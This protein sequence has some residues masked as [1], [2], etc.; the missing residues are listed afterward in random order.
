MGSSR[1]AKAAK[2]RLGAG[3]QSDPISE[4][5]NDFLNTV[6]NINE[7]AQ[8][9]F[10]RDPSRA[11]GNA[12]VEQTLRNYF[13]S[14]CYDSSTQNGVDPFLQTAAQVSNFK[15]ERGY[16]FE[17]CIDSMRESASAVN[18]IN[19]MVGMALPMYKNILMNMVWDKGGI[20]HSTAEAQTF[21]RTMKIRQLIDQQGRAIDMFLNQ[22]DMTAAMLSVNPNIDV[23][24]LN[25]ERYNTEIVYAKL[26]GTSFDHIDNTA[27]ISAIKIKDVY[28]PEDS[29]LPD[30]NGIIPESGG[31]VATS[32]TAG[33]Y[34]VWYNVRLNFGPGYGPIKRQLQKPITFKVLRKIGTADP[35]TVT[36]SDVIQAN[37][38]DDL[39]MVT[40]GADVVAVKLNCRIDAS[41]RTIKPCT[42][43]W[44]EITD[45]VS[46]GTDTGIG[47]QV[48]PEALKDYKT[49]YNVDQTTE[50]MSLMKTAMANRRD[51]VIK[52]DIM[53][54]Y[55]R[56]DR[57]SKF[58]GTFDYAPRDGYFDTHIQ[59]RIDTFW[60]YLDSAVTKMY[61]VLNDP[62]LSVC[63]FGDPDLVRR[64]TPKTYTYQA[65]ASIGPV[66]LDF[67]KTVV[68]SDKRVYSFIGS[69]KLRNSTE[70]IIVLCPRNTDRVTYIIY[71]YQFYISNEIRDNDNPALPMITCFD[72]FKVDEY[73]P[74]QARLTIANPSGLKPGQTNTVVMDH[75]Y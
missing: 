71:D 51:D 69:D 70:F 48:T 17:N 59:W 68:T 26:G 20:P 13:L 66:E 8:L 22:N 2:Q 24:L 30:S 43:G 29:V 49:M 56:L 32:E 23:E 55:D 31:V 4:F 18:T 11:L 63:V 38:K 21:P 7:G 67:S 3:Y 72:R 45:T 1:Q 41:M 47:C 53:S 12:T 33:N 37:Q 16:M 35:T 74:I 25:G 73:Q 61:Q 60:E 75:T 62:N 54:S 36:I 39:F 28:F 44:T 5:A 15:K 46:I 9:D 14:E 42:V 27:F 50:L 10:F 6:H 57:G 58:K 40:A 19:P 52:T 65:P 34:A 64:I